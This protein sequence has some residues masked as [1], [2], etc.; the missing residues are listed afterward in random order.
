MSRESIVQRLISFLRRPDALEG[1][2][3]QRVHN[4]YD[5]Y[6]PRE[7]SQEAPAAESIEPVYA[8]SNAP[9]EVEQEPTQDFVNTYRQ[10]GQASRLDALVMKAI[11]QFNAQFGFVVRYD[12]D[13]RMRY[14]TG[15]DGRGQ[16]VAH[17]SIEPD[18]HA[19][20][21]VLRSG[22]SQ[23]FIQ[24]V[25][26]T[27]QRGAV[28]CGPLWVGDEVIG[29]LYLDNPSGNHLHRGIFDVYC[30]QAARMLD[31]EYVM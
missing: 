10:P 30:S 3:V 21:L 28:L 16:Y 6:T 4:S 17:T 7:V 9:V 13:G 19:V 25:S 14:C 11:Q 29:V 2:S 5:D 23:L 8:V 22:E 27:T 26:N 24:Q 12:K 15:R 18:R 31:N 1:D 20:F